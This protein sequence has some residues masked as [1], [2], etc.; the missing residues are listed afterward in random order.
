MARQTQYRNILEMFSNRIEMHNTWTLH[1]SYIALHKHTIQIG[2]RV[3][4]LVREW[5]MFSQRINKKMYY[6]ISDKWRDI[7]VNNKELI[8]PNR[9]KKNPKKTKAET[10][11][12]KENKELNSVE[13]MVKSNE[14]YMEH[15][16]EVMKRI[17]A[18][19]RLLSYFRS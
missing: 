10:E 11:I 18:W 12:K 2:T 3:C 1:W 6:W 14:Q 4:D 5:Y 16:T 7:I 9:Y 13:Q 19:D 15:R 17:S 8:I